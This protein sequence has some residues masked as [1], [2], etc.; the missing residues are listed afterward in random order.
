MN[1]TKLWPIL[2]VLLAGSAS[3]SDASL[4]PA[5]AGQRLSAHE[6]IIFKPTVHDSRF[7]DIP[8]SAARSRCEDTRPPEALA[9]PNPLLLGVDVDNPVRV[10]FIVGTDGRV[11][12]PLIL[13]GAD[14]SRDRMVLD[15]VRHWKYR[16]ATCNGVPTEVEA[17]IEFS[18]R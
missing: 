7:A 6:Q 11:H 10:S 18:R 14:P 5:S 16:P 9:T 13:E 2:L 8:R 17:K 1:S 4:C 15:A 3:V 12:S